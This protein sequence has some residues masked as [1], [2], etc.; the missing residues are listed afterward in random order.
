MISAQLSVTFRDTG[1]IQRKIVE[2]EENGIKRDV[3]EN[4][5]T[6]GNINFQLRPTINYVVKQPD[7]PAVLFQ[8]M[9]NGPLVSNS[10]YRSTTSGGVQLRST[11]RNRPSPYPR[12]CR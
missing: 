9:F 5:P 11:W 3:A 4:I 7:E 8:R 6:A 12:Q 2:I 10:F 1:S